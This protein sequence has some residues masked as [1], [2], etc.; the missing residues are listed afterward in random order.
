[1]D[2]DTRIVS[3]RNAY[4][5]KIKSLCASCQHKCIDNSGIRVCAEMMLNVEQNFNCDSWKMSEGLNNAGKSNG[6]VKRREY[7]MFIQE[8]RIAENDDIKKGIIKAKERKTVEEIRKMFT[9]KFGSIYAI[10]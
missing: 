10:E 3:V 8:I 5:Y 6:K 1:M 9:E 2:K 4:G 7:L